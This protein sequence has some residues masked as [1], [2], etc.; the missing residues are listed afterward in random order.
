MKIEL[1]EI[2]D[3]IVIS[4][5]EGKI[6]WI[7]SFQNTF[8]Y[9]LHFIGHSKRYI[10]IR[11]LTEFKFS[12]NGITTEI[13]FEDNTQFYEELNE[14]KTVFINTNEYQLFEI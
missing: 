8:N 5:K 2:K 7:N 4:L 9:L 6:F 3:K 12:E 1:N 11:K 13:Y 10:I 14:I